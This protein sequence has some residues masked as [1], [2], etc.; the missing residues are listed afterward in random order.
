MTPDILNH[1]SR[2]PLLK[3]VI[4][5]TQVT[6]PETDGDVYARLIRAIIFQQLS[7]KA[8]STIYGRFIDLFPEAYPEP[9]L[10][11]SKD[12]ATLRSVGLSRQKSGYLHNVAEFFQ[13]E[14]LMDKD[15]SDWED[16]ALLKYLTQIKGVGKWTV[17][18]LLM[19]TLNRPDIL[20]V[21]DLGIQQA[22][23]LLY[24]FEAKGRHLKEK[25]EEISEPWRP[26]R[27]YASLYLW[28]WKESVKVK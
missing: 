16:D 26:Y 27:T 15:W 23:Q 22:M 4:E 24:G 28:R 2:D 7:G 8:A 9:G 5:S 12:L 3:S 21:D 11:L 1:L 18:M 19:F 10:L 17:E 20:P 6:F 13:Q 14:Q 25:M